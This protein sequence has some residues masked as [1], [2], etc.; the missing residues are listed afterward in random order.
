MKTCVVCQCIIEHEDR[1]SAAAVAWSGIV[2]KAC[3]ERAAD[4]LLGW[5]HAEKRD[6][7]L[8]QEHQRQL[9]T[10]AEL[11][12]RYDEYL[13]TL[14]GDSAWLEAWALDPRNKL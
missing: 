2:H 13:K 9:R 6:A 7:W 11:T 12:E 14:R 8:E 1:D 10:N 3:A 4:D 5:A